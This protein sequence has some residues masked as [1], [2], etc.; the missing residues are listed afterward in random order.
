[1]RSALEPNEY[2]ARYKPVEFP[3][4]AGVRPE[5][6]GLNVQINMAT[7]NSN[8]FRTHYTA[9]MFLTLAAVLFERQVTMTRRLKQRALNWAHKVVSIMQKSIERKLKEMEPFS[10]QDMRDELQNRYPDYCG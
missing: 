7:V 5:A 1:M 9:A 4:L 10:E 3:R 6:P 2:P 8:R